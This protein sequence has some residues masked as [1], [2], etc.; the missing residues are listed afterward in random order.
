MVQTPTER[1][2]ILDRWT[3]PH[4]LT[5]PQ[6][7]IWLVPLSV[8]LVIVLAWEVFEIV[9][10]GQEAGWAHRLVDVVVAVV[11]W[12]VVSHLLTLTSDLPIR[13]V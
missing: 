5:G 8:M 12:L 2:G 4:T 11:G 6:F 10:P 9:I 3:I 7:A 13:F 1:L